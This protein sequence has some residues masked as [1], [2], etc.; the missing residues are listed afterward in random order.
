ME[1]GV[2]MGVYRS[3]PSLMG[4]RLGWLVYLA[5]S[6]AIIH[7]V[8]FLLSFLGFLFLFLFVWTPPAHSPSPFPDPS[9]HD[10]FL[11]SNPP[12]LALLGGTFCLFAH[13][14]F[15]SICSL[16]FLGQ[17]GLLRFF[18]GLQ[19]CAGW[20]MNFI[21]LIDIILT[22]EPIHSPQSFGSGVDW[23]LFVC[24]VCSS[25]LLVVPPHRRELM[26]KKTKKNKKKNKKRKKKIE[27]VIVAKTLL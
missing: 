9:Y 4:F 6:T 15:F 2:W 3:L 24:V 12:P 22:G 16:K 18:F 5:S 23:G 25:F 1:V 8:L 27:I 11:L 26:K 10:S 7:L 13:M 21:L 19:T 20:C 17:L 14:L